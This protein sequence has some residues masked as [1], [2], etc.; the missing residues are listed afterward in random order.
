VKNQYIVISLFLAIVILMTSCSD[1]NEFNV[2]VPTIAIKQDSPYKTTFEDLGVGVLFDFDF[3]LPKADKRWVNLWV[4]R[5]IDGIKDSQ[6]LAQLTY[7]NSPKEVEEGSLGFGMINPSSEH[8]LV[9]LYGPAVK[10]S[11]LLIEK[12]YEEEDLRSLTWDYAI[13]NEEI[14]LTV[15]ETKILAVY[16]GTEG[17]ISN[18]VD[19]ADE[20]SVDTMLKQNKVVLLLKIKI[21]EEALKVTDKLLKDYRRVGDT[22]VHEPK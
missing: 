20:K 12:D 7:G 3:Y 18:T 8:T 22:F 4:E 2:D 14:E 5:Y 6:P 13:G 21:V 19:F 15:G 11:P 9:F 1:K 17:N 16:R 10:S